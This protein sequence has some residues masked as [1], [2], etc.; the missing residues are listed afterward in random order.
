MDNLPVKDFTKW[1]D[2]AFCGQYNKLDPEYSHQMC[3]PLLL[4]DGTQLSIQASWGHYCEPC[5]NSPS[6]SYEFYESFEIGYPTKEILEIAQYAADPDNLT[7]T[8]YSRV[9]KET[10]RDFIAKRGGVVGFKAKK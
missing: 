4:A 2:E 10:I 9:P 1:M 7:G 6:G 8:V 3:A 5:K